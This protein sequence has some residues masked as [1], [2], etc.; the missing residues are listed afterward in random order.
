MVCWSARDELRVI[1]H[2]ILMQDPLLPSP[3]IV[4]CDGPWELR[5]PG[6]SSTPCYSLFSLQLRPSAST[7]LPADLDLTLSNTP[8]SQQL[9]ILSF[10]NS[11]DI[12]STTT[13][14]LPSAIP[15]SPSC[16]H[17]FSS[18]LGVGRQGVVIDL[19]DDF[20]PCYFP[21]SSSSIHP[22]IPLRLIFLFLSITPIWTIPSSLSLLFY[23]ESDVPCMRVSPYS[24]FLR[25]MLPLFFLPRYKHLSRYLLLYALFCSVLPC[26]AL[27][28]LCIF[29]FYYSIEEQSKISL[30]LRTL[31]T[32][33]TIDKF[34]D[35]LNIRRLLTG[36]VD[37]GLG[38]GVN[39]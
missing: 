2:C 1:L 19:A 16:F 37:V 24:S 5:W 23:L 20:R 26:S 6:L 38:L 36:A 10:T 9:N 35:D 14:L 27:F 21:S 25:S 22:S 17:P 3:I 7:C 39:E 32:G 15:H 11:S 18:S 12:T 28:C 30:D 33:L 31:Q 34:F 4:A 8:L 29:S 13:I